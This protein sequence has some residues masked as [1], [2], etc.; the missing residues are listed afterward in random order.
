MVVVL[1]VRSLILESRTCGR[2]AFKAN[3]IA[4]NSR[5]LICNLRSFAD[6]MPFTCKP[7]R[8]APQP[9][10]DAS[11]VKKIGGVFEVKVQP[12]KMFLGLVH[13]SSEFFI[14]EVICT[15]SSQSPVICF[16]WEFNCS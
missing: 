1:S 5:I 6:Q 7:C 2:N 15:K 9:V 11:V 10:R 13:H 3:L 14:D 4:V 16:N 8:W 12:A